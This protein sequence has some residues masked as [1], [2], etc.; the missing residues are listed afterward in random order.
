MTTPV[1]KRKAEADAPRR[2]RKRPYVTIERDDLT[3][4][5]VALMQMNRGARPATRF[6]LP[7]QAQVRA[8]SN[9]RTGGMVG[10]EKK[11]CDI[12]VANALFTNN[13]WV[14]SVMDNAGTSCLNGIAIGDGATNRDGR[15]YGIHSVHIRGTITVDFQK[16]MVNP[17]ADTVVRMALVIDKQTNGVVLDPTG[18]FS[19]GGGIAVNAFRNLEYIKRFRVIEDMT[20]RI[21]NEQVAEAANLFASSVK[22]VPFVMNHEFK[23]P[24]QVNCI[25]TGATIASIA[26]TSLHLIGT[27]TSD[28]ISILGTRYT[29]TSRVR[30]VG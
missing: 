18:V 26:D 6:V 1:R 3:A 7:T 29:Y 28:A 11:Y 17:S 22:I 30:F 16:S 25:G 9:A 15:Q 2:P 24:L 8:I 23:T 27:A 21:N 12:A 5:D 10:Q 4:R 20:I 14:G 19:L 13:N